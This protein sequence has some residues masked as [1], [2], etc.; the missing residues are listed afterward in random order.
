MKAPLVQR[1]R[2]IAPDT[3]LLCVLIVLAPQLFG[4]AFSWS[5][6]AIA[7]FSLAAL[8]T[9]LWRRRSAELP[10]WDALLVVASL[11]WFWTCLQ[12]VPL[13]STVASALDLPAV[14]AARRLENL[15]WAGTIP[16]TISYAPG[17]TLAQIVAGVAVVSAFVTARLGGARA[18]PSIASAVVVSALLLGFEGFLH[19]VGGIG[20]V[21]G[22]YEPRFTEPQLL[23]P[24]MN[25]NHLGGF[26]LFGALLAAGLSVEGSRR[27]RGGWALASAACGLVVAATL[28]RGAIGSLLFG[29]VLLAAWL[30]RRRSSDRPGAIIPVAVFG[31][32]LAG[33]LAFAGL[34][35]ILRRFEA[36]G[37]DKLA[38]AARGFRVLEGPTWWLGVGRGAFSSTFVAEEG[39]LARYTHP[40]NILVQWTTEWGVPLALALFLV[41]AVA[42]WKR[43]RGTEDPLVAAG[44]VAVLSLVLQNFVDFSLEMAGIAVV[45]AAVLGTLLPSAEPMSSRGGARGLGALAGLMTL[46]F[47][48][49]APRV[50]HADT[51][52]IVDE[53][54]AAMNRDDQQAFESTLRR[55]LALHPGEPAFALLAGT[56]AGRKRHPDAA[57]WLSIVMAEAPG[58]AAPHVITA[59]LLLDREQLDQALLEIAEAEQRHPGSAQRTICRMLA[60]DPS[61]EHLMRAAPEPEL[62][63]RYFDRASTCARLPAQLRAEIDAAIL[64]LAPTESSAVLREARRLTAAGDGDAARELVAAALTE[65]PNDARLWMATI[66]AQLG[67]G[68]VAAARATLEEAKATG[69]VDRAL[70]EAEARVEAASGDAEGMRRA[71]TRMRG[72][73]RGS[74]ERVAAAFVV[75]AQLEASLGNVEQALAAY[76]AAELAHPGGL[77]LYYAATLALQSGMPTYARRTFRSLCARDPGGR[78]C[79]EEVRLSGQPSAR[80]AP[81]ELP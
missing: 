2:D 44:C 62:Q 78:A 16:L 52:S 76:E 31:A 51:Q 1:A 43:L 13:P 58:W 22:I 42:L 74:A 26:A 30:H 23:T 40:E 77:A 41:A 81:N 60:S 72:Q 6:V 21:F 4:G 75:E 54:S 36:Q 25:G 8:W 15:A 39:S 33:T 45:V 9:A 69:T 70:I 50:L 34:E 12:A 49:V 53:L 67:E 56:Y 46:A 17:S 3:A 61:M 71:M 24:L 64:R 63:V 18:L 55:G 32:A 57:R 28:S 38:I 80:P 79:A 73:S 20:A 47:I 14:E 11:A 35:P 19:R 27:A 48:V 10:R 29:F 66:R 7:G 68:D 37:L 5:V 59:E 65:S